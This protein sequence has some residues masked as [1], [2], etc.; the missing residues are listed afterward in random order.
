AAAV[1]PASGPARPGARRRRFRGVP[2]P[3]TCVDADRGA[4]A[5][6]FRYGRNPPAGERLGA[7]RPRC[8]RGCVGAFERPFGADES[9]PVQAAMHPAWIR[10]MPCSIELF[11]TVP[12]LNPFPA[13][14]WAEVFPED[15]IW[16]EPVW[17]DPGDV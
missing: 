1:R 6:R 17:C 3:G 10:L 2:G 16:N 8:E 14:W 9:G 12:S 15:D 7:V 13:S 11:R 4:A 5:D